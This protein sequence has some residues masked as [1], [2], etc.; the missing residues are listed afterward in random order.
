MLFSEINPYIRY[1]RYLN[2]TKDS[3]FDT[4]V[5]LDA[6]LFY[7]LDGYGKIK[8]KNCEYEME[9]GSLIIINSG[10]PY[11]IYTPEISVNFVAINFD[12][13]H[14]TAC[15]NT[16]VI[17]VEESSFK[18]EMLID[19]NV[20]DDT[21]VLS[22]V[23]YIKKIPHIQKSLAVIVREYMQQLLYYE[24]RCG[25]ILA[26][27]IAESMR[28]Y[29]IGIVVT[30]SSIL[31][32]IHE[33]FSKNITNLSIGSHFCYHPNYINSLVI[34]LTGMS[35]HQY[36]IKVRLTN[37]AMLLENTTLSCEEIATSCGFCDPAH[38]SKC[39][40]KHFGINPSKYRN[41]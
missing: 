5:A 13:T 4:V 1:A 25:H 9:P 22:E 19:Y 16:P 38:F 26:Q 11:R 15:Y 3:V 35:V 18:K 37:A 34:R 23:L 7:V 14:N 41:I 27:I 17:P 8:V 6:R 29:E 21:H 31:S 32:Y 39:F 10:I 40:K 20:F 28:F 2:L 24:S 33:N 30:E 36:I 12:F